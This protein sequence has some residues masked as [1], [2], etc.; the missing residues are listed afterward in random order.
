VKRKR[1]R[2]QKEERVREGSRWFI[3]ELWWPGPSQENAVIVVELSSFFWR[4]N[5][6]KEE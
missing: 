5:A 4:S 3:Y 1:K 6:Q 2:K